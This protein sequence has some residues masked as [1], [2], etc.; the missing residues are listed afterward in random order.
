V[1]GLGAPADT[2]EA[3]DVGAAGLTITF[4]VGPGVF[5]PERALIAAD[6]RPAALTPLPAFRGDALEERWSGGELLII[7][8]ADD[9][10]VTLHAVHNLVRIARGA[11]RLRWLQRGFLPAA[12]KAGEV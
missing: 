7:A 8:A 3:A 2:G 4:G 12:A 5:A 9:P 1:A 6:R 10:Q 11:A